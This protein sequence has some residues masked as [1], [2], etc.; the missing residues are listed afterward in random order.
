MAAILLGS[1]AGALE[2]GRAMPWRF[3]APGVGLKLQAVSSA[4]EDAPRDQAPHHPLDDAVVER[5]MRRHAPR[6]DRH[7]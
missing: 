7:R 4:L 1:C 2:S 3:P 5:E 6:A